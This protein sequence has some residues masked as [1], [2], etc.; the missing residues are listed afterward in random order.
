MSTLT[1][2]EDFELDVPAVAVTLG[3]CEETVRRLIRQ[4]RLKAMRAGTR[5]YRIK[6]S[7]LDE[8]RASTITC[9]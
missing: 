6:A 4:K 5:G 3:A 9:A 2:T 1:T 8:Y 7:W